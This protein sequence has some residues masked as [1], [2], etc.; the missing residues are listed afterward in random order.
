MLAAAERIR[1]SAVSKPKPQAVS[2]RPRVETCLQPRLLVLSAA[3]GALLA[4]LLFALGT[5]LPV[6]S[7]ESAAAPRTSPSEPAPSRAAS[8]LP[9]ARS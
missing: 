8:A 9:K 5:F 4:L 1:I 7:A 6:G 2:A 3:A